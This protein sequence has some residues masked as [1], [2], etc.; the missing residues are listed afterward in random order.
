MSGKK[1]LPG[2]ISVGQEFLFP[3]TELMEMP[4]ELE[5]VSA[6]NGKTGIQIL[7]QCQ[8]KV[9]KVSVE[10]EGFGTEYFQLIDVPV[11][12]NTGSVTDQGGDMVILPEK[13]PDYAIRLAPFR[14]YDCLKPAPDGKIVSTDGRA[15][16]YLCLCP[17][18]DIAPGQYEL[19][20]RITADGMEHICQIHFKVF[21]VA[22]EENRFHMTN[23]FS[24]RVIEKFHKTKRGTPEFYEMLRKYARAMRRMHQNTFAIFL[25][26]GDDLEKQVPCEHF[27]FD[28]IKHIIEVFFEEG[29]QTLE[30]GGLL[31][32][33]SRPDGTP[34]MYSNNLKCSFAPT[35]PADSEKGFVLLNQL[36]RD[37]AD[38]LHSNGWQ[39][40]VLFH[41]MDEPDVHYDSEETLQARR[42]Q[43]FMTANIVRK[44]LPTA[45]I[46]DAV[47]TTRFR[48]AIDIMVPI[49]FSYQYGKEV[50]DQIKAAGDDV[51]TYVCCGPQAFWL[52]RFLDQPLV[53]GRLL[54]WGCAANRLPGFLHW[55][56]NQFEGIP[57]LSRGTSCTNNTGLGTNFPCGDA[58][59]VYPGE[60]GPWLSMRLEAARRGA[61]DAAL[62]DA[63]YKKDSEAHDQLIARVFQSF[64]EYDN[65]PM[66]VE[67]VHRE[68]LELL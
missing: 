54:F 23:W 32:R 58:F 50:F 1:Y 30:T 22:F 28:H 44:H 46:I 25:D 7:F 52:N 39:D 55:G 53:N 59:V 15:A 42:L 19:T 6:R 63:L 13:C 24:V 8:D 33:G 31:T 64:C 9:G 41:V 43:Y 40:K 65:D 29:F 37:F 56:F 11:E 21:Q 2:Y 68:L 62:L 35:V 14:V 60:D 17:E 12:Y 51:W 4:K 38:F 3:D 45:R 27:S 20:L 10:G 18:E 47:Q 49:T 5:L 61:E 66:H 67:Q 48:G 34:D 16:M 26:A 36:M 57:D